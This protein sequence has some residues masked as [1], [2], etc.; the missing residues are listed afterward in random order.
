MPIALTVTPPLILAV[1]LV[2]SGIAKLRNPDDLDGWEAMGVPAALRRTWLLRLHPW[3]EII[4]G[5]ALAALGA[6]LG[7]AAAIVA[8]ALMGASTVVIAR[9]LRTGVDTECACF[10][11]RKTITAMTLVRNVWYVLLA[12]VA[13]V[14]AG[15]NPLWGG[16][17]AALDGV[18]WGWIAGL[19]AAAITVALTMWPTDAADSAAEQQATDAVAPGEVD[20][21][22]M[23]DYIRSRTPAVPVTLSDG[24]EVTLRDLSMRQPLIVMAVKPGCG[25]CV[26]VMDTIPKW[27]EL[28]PE[29]SIRQLLT[30][31]PDEGKHAEREEPLSIHDPHRYVQRSLADWQTPTAVLFGADG[32]LAG[33]PVTGFSAISEF[34]ADV[35]ESLHGERPAGE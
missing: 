11:A 17:L 25:P 12:I 1:V 5:I 29:V 15:M 13:V 16:A 20:E 31:A 33:G 7:L 2:V 21:D 8:L 14:V 3:G 4:L 18:G 19:A 10:G 28:L 24:T 32:M 26:K 27:R 23:L 9:T 6:G 30:Y 22:G 34:I 35:Y